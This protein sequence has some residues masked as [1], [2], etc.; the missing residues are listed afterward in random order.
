MIPKKIHYCWFGGKPKPKLAEKCIASWRKFCPDFE[1]VE[2]NESNY[3][4]TAHPYTK[5][6]FERGM[7]A[8]LSDYVRLDVEYREGGIYFDTDVE[9]IRD[10]A[11]L[12]K[13]HAF[14]AFENDDFVATGL[15]FGAEA[16]HPAL[17]AMMREY[18]IFGVLESDFAPVGCPTL[19]TQALEDFGLVRNGLEQRLGDIL[20]F[21]AEWMNPLD[22]ATGRLN[23]TD[24]TV[25]IH[26]YAKSALKRSDRIRSRLT[27]PLHR[28][29]GKDFFSRK[30]RRVRKEK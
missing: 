8:F 24:K 17:A 14:F 7:W 29:L 1:I 10:P 6:C 30:G 27:R 15:G 2:W 11:K 16:G 4:V 23:V 22:D 9:L 25:S 18:D 12:L 21:P 3:D 19:N 26:W 28:L 20:I 5:S 13:E